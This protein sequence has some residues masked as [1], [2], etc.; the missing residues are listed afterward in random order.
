MGTPREKYKK[1]GGKNKH[2]KNLSTQPAVNTTLYTE[3]DR[4]DHRDKITNRPL[5]G[6]QQSLIDRRII[7]RN[8]KETAQEFNER[9]QHK[10]TMFD[11]VR[12][13]DIS[14]RKIR[15]FFYIYG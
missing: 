15:Q 11:E 10:R 1:K 14:I 9:Q 4:A 7:A 8:W 5:S 13:D 6:W 2:R 12:K 3:K